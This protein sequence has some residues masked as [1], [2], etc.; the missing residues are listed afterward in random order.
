MFT[1]ECSLNHAE[2]LRDEIDLVTIAANVRNI[3]SRLPVHVKHWLGLHDHWLGFQDD[4]ACVTTVPELALLVEQ[5][6]AT[7]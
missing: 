6:R 1:D 3:A 5:V 2:R 7:A 4:L